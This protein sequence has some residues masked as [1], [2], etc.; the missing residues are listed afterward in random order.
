MNVDRRNNVGLNSH[1]MGEGRS[2][3][4]R[5]DNEPGEML[6]TFVG[7]VKH[8]CKNQQTGIFSYC[9][10]ASP[11]PEYGDAFL[12]P[13]EIE[14]WRDGFKEVELGAV[15]KFDLY[16]TSRGY[17]ARNVEVKREEPPAKITDFK[18]TPPPVAAKP[19][20]VKNEQR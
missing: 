20:E 7:K 19:L 6:G 3:Q 13:R 11:G 16:R 14:P 10:I 4:R 2:M 15:V 17:Q 18:T 8:V 5:T 9:F 1:R 12:H